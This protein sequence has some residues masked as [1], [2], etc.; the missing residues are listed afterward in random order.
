MDRYADIY[1]DIC[2]DIR[3]DMYTINEGVDERYAEIHGY[4]C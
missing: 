4:I 2:G 1:V 3:R